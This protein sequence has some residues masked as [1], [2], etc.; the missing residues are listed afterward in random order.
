MNEK[1]K[2][3]INIMCIISIIL[4]IIEYYILMAYVYL[5]LSDFKK[6]ILNDTRSFLALIVIMLQVAI[7]LIII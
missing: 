7:M 6:K 5:P 3:I 2:F 4:V 1:T